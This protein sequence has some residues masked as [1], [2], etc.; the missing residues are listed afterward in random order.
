MPDK[1]EGLVRVLQGGG[2]SPLGRIFGL[3]PVCFG[4]E[5]KLDFGC[6]RTR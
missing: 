1:V 6:I 2:S 3:R 5:N 4:R